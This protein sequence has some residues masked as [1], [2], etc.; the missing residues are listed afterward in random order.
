MGTTNADLK[1]SAAGERS[2]LFR[3]NRILLP[4]RALSSETILR[5]G[6]KL[7]KTPL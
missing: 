7:E 5:T 6:S 4:N 2:E 3:L 1:T